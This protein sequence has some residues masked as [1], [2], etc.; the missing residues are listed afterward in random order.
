MYGCSYYVQRALFYADA[1]FEL[2]DDPESYLHYYYHEQVLFVRD[3][4]VEMEIPFTLLEQ[5]NLEKA[6]PNLQAVVKLNAESNHFSSILCFVPPLREEASDPNPV[7]EVSE[8]SKVLFTL[9]Q[10]SQWLLHRRLDS[11]F[12]PY[13]S[14]QYARHSWL[15]QRAFLAT[16]RGNDSLRFEYI[17]VILPTLIVFIILAHSFSLLYSGS[18]E[19]TPGLHFLAVGHQWFWSYELEAFIE[20]RMGVSHGE[21]WI[22]RGKPTYLSLKAAFDSIP[23]PESALSFGSRRL[24]EVDHPLI[25]PVSV[26]LKALATSGDVLHSWA[27]PEMGIK[28]DAVPGRINDSFSFIQRPGVFYGQCSELCGVGHGFMPIV[29]EAVSVPSF[30]TW[31]EH[32]ED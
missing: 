9:Q 19:V 13:F 25:L 21:A 1:L 15:P 18:E 3:L 27:V 14:R 12:T 7:V 11:Y 2:R 6:H 17:C 31:A 8:E 32:N 20:K 30:I 23:V 24:L 5:W 28:I 10:S 29:V 16:Q 22:P 4:M 26:P